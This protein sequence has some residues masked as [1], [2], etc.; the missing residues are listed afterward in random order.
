[1]WIFHYVDF[2]IRF[3]LIVWYFVIPFLGGF[4]PIFSLCEFWLLHFYYM[5][6]FC[7]NYPC[8]QNLQIL[9]PNALPDNT[10]ELCGELNTVCLSNC[11][12]VN[13]HPLLLCEFI[14]YHFYFIFIGFS[15]FSHFIYTMWIFIYVGFI[16]VELISQF[17]V[18]RFIS[19]LY[20]IIK[21]FPKFDSTFQP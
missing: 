17:S 6:S 2:F 3:I 5:F 9:I 19:S 4:L 16:Y 21:L 1:M 11:Y 7:I 18:C 8:V 20:A 10:T 15:I 13:F 14:H 12:C